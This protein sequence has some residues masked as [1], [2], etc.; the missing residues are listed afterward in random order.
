MQ[1]KTEYR[2]HPKEWNF[3]LINVELLWTRP[4]R[5]P[6]TDE[7]KLLPKVLP[8]EECGGSWNWRPAVERQKCLRRLSAGFSHCAFW[9][10]GVSGWERRWGKRVVCCAGINMQLTDIHVFHKM[11]SC[12]WQNCLFFSVTGDFHIKLRAVWLQW[13]ISYLFTDHKPCAIKNENAD[14]KCSP[15][16]CFREQ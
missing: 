6:W 7:T 12:K 4:V 5:T 11:N 9:M 2:K 10:N 8:V 15:L 13:E 3:A 16:S 1:W 14:L